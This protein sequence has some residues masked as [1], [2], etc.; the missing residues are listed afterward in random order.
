MRIAY[1]FEMVV[2]LQA[3]WKRDSGEEEAWIAR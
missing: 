2:V 3:Y 1:F